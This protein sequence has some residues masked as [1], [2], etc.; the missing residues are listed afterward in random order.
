MASEQNLF[1]G[2]A[3]L[4][5]KTHIVGLLRAA[6]SDPV[7]CSRIDIF[8]S[9]WQLVQR[10]KHHVKPR[11]NRIMKNSLDGT[12][13]LIR[14]SVNPGNVEA[15]WLEWL[16]KR[17]TLLKE[18]EIE[19]VVARTN[20]RNKTANSKVRL[21]EQNHIEDVAR[22]KAAFGTRDA[23]LLANLPN[24]DMWYAW[25][26]TRKETI[27][28]FLDPDYDRSSQKATSLDAKRKADNSLEDSVAH[29][30]RRPAKQACRGTG[31]SVGRQPIGTI[32]DENE[33]AS[34]AHDTLNDTGLDHPLVQPG[35]TG[36]GEPFP[37]LYD[38][39]SSI[40]DS[41]DKQIQYRW[42][43]ISAMETVLEPDAVPVFNDALCIYYNVNR[44]DVEKLPFAGLSAAIR[45][46][47]LWRQEIVQGLSTT[48]C[49]R[50]AFPH[51]PSAL[52]GPYC[53]VFCTVSAADAP[54]QACG[55]LPFYSPSTSSI[56]T[57]HPSKDTIRSP[58]SSVYFCP[59]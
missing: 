30:E 8:V 44:S 35:W 19:R 23:V 34:D 22:F 11:G 10:E 59:V 3:D 31:T 15:R 51:D 9:I 21:M 32:I 18:A 45:R 1:C 52:L 20:K 29:T 37:L 26:K 48:A 56:S 24:V 39:Q 2:S 36:T 7:L 55:L 54:R 49:L 33:C 47:P 58:S 41:T 46:S 14:S 5:K 13:N 42:S 43:A 25:P 38:G 53:Y 57:V 40:A 28:Y 16:N 50:I 4:M 27:L 12:Y 17:D 6:E